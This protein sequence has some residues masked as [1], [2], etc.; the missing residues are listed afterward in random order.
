MENEKV[1]KLYCISGFDEEE[2]LSFS[3]QANIDRMHRHGEFVFLPKDQLLPAL[4]VYDEVHRKRPGEDRL[5]LYVADI[6]LLSVEKA[7]EALKQA[8]V[9]ER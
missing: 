4:E 7:Q 5:R 9:V 3:R 2:A 8:R 1:G 6:T